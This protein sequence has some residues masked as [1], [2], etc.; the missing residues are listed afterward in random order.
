MIAVSKIVFAFS[1]N[2]S[3]SSSPSRSALTSSSTL[4][5]SVS[6]ITSS[7]AVSSSATTSSPSLAGSSATTSSEVTSSSETVSSVF[8]ASSSATTS[9]PSSISS[10]TASLGAESAFAALELTTSLT[11]A[12]VA[13]GVFSLLLSSSGF[14]FSGVGPPRSTQSRS[15]AASDVYKR[16]P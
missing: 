13:P 8:A 1:W 5:A 10:D 6:A 7:S 2:S 9:C 3:E 4:I 15:S 14:E 11:C 16:Q 12:S